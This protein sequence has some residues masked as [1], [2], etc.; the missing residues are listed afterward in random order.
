LNLIRVMPAEGWDAML[1]S[2]YLARLI[3]PVMLAV[4]L[5]LLVNRAAFR[6]IARQFVDSTA[7]VFLSGLITMTGG[8]AILLAHRVIA[9]DW[10]I[11]ITL[12]G[13]AMAVAGAIRIVFPD[14]MAAVGRDL[15]ASDAILWA[16][17]AVW[18]AIGA[19]LT[20][21]GYWPPSPTP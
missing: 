4:G 3:G 5:G 9:P 19:I 8:V 16:A 7:L 15:L 10:R 2:V 18:L 6:A 12:I 11:L 13:L 14:R 20:L 17:A 1:T 21:A